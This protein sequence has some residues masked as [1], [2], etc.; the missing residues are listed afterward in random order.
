MLERLLGARF[1]RVRAE[2][3]AGL[4]QIGHPEAGES[5]LAD[6]SAAVRAT[7][8]WAVR[9][10][11]GTRPNVTGSCS[12]RLTTQRCAGSSRGSASAARSMTRS[13]SAAI[14]GMPG[15]GYARSGT[16]HAP[17]GRPAREDRGMLTDPAPIVVRAALA[18]LR[19][20][21]QL[22]PTDLLW[23]LLQADQPRHVRR[24]AFSLL[25]GRGN[26]TRIE[27]DLRSVVDV[28]DN[29]RAHAS[30]DLSG[31]LDREASTAYRCRTRPPSI[32]WA[33][34]RCCGTEHR[35]PRGPPASLAPGLSD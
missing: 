19:G 17:P 27:A 3:L 5:L 16:C 2:A 30:T 35:C 32:A 31:W 22:P 10:A 28:D 8:Q 34:H 18:A 4:V 12:C 25:V 33:A 23:E 24:A 13:R 26:W 1:T 7:A 11:A 9:R 21:P 29:L 14:S 15:R 6:R 20:Q